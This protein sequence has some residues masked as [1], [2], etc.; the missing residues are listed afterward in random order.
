MDVDASPVLLVHGLGASTLSWELVAAELATTLR[1][2]VTAIDLPG[3]G[4]T[5]CLDRAADFATH[6]SVISAYLDE[7]GPA[8][9]MGN[10]MGGALA[11]SVAAARPELVGGLVLVDAAYPRPGRNLEQLTRTLRFAALTVPRVAAPLLGARSRRLGP[12]RLVDATIQFVLA[13]PDR[14]DRSLRQRLVALATER[15]HYPEA[16][17]AYAQSGGSLFRHLLSDMRGDLDAIAAPTLVLHGRR[18]QLVPVAY[19]RAVAERRTDWRYVELAD[20]GHAPQ[21]ETA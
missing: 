13:E 18:D 5:R 4:R 19:A 2:R 3:F 8:L 1:R 14:L 15:H 10:S 20:C 21:L 9:V 16:A 11:A 17:T 7:R 6:R 12:E